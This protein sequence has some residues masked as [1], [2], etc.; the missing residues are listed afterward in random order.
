MQL[1]HDIKA[2]EEKLN[3]KPY[4]AAISRLEMQHIDGNITPHETWAILRV[5]ISQCISCGASA[6]GGRSV[7]GQDFCAE[8]EC[9]ALKN[10]SNPPVPRGGERSN[11]V[12]L[13]KT[14]L[15]QLQKLQMLSKTPVVKK[16]WRVSSA[17]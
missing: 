8:K 15:Y 7:C 16:K 11:T 3:T 17:L 4:P 9:H 14:T 13:L 5:T 10:D 1:D 2:I 12:V 6:A